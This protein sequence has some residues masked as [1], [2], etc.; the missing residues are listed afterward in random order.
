MPIFF[1]A[2]K[3]NHANRRNKMKVKKND[4]MPETASE[5]PE[6]KINEQPKTHM[7][8]KTIEKSMGN[9][10]TKN[11]A[12]IAKSGDTDLRRGLKALNKLVEKTG[13]NPRDG[14]MYGFCNKKDTVKIIQQKKDGVEMLVKKMFEVITFWPEYQPQ[15]EPGYM[16]ILTGKDKNDFLGKLGCP[17]T[18]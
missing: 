12:F 14:N 4:N 3:V 10:I 7:S 16:I 18:L 6:V 1:R 17:K 11:P 9:P 5:K 15:G 13:R 2:R 8:T